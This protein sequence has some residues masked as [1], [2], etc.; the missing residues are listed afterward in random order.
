MSRIAGKLALV[1][2]ASAGIGL[3]CAQR[4]AAMGAHLVLWA[5]R[6]ERL[7]PAAEDL[8]RAH[9]ITVR[10]AAVDVRDRA[11]VERATAELVAAGAVPD[12]LVNNAGLA[13][14]LDKLQE[15]DPDDWDR[16][17]D[18]NVKGLLYVSR[19]WLP[20]MVARRRGHVVN[21]GSL[22]GHQTYPKGNV[23]GATKYAVRA[24]TEGM[25]LDLV[26]TPIRVSS[27]DPGLVETEFSV[28][29]FGGDAARAKAVYQGMQPLT[30]ADV[31]EVVAY[32]VDLPEHVNVLDV[33]LMPVAQRSTQ[34]VHREE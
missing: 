26:G 15:G 19:A 1:T 17:I 16:M 13:A 2:G 25:Y 22:A 18:T 9:G 3:A 5:R 30:A 12:I 11:A 32:V 24:L 21:L 33:V 20:H 6:A 34:V 28:V 27:I 10:S 7:D 31:A 29:R 4:F 8:R 14:G 23:Y